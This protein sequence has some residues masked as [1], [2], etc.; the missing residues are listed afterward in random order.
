MATASK[1]AKG[2]YGRGNGPCHAGV[3]TSTFFDDAAILTTPGML[4]G[5]GANAET[6]RA[7]EISARIRSILLFA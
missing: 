6:A 4:L 3:S 7:A 5:R 2:I 1:D